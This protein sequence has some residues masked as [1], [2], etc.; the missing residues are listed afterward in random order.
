[1][2]VSFLGLGRMGSAMAERLLSSGVDLIVYNRTRE[3]AHPLLAKGASWAD[4]PRAASHNCEILLT[5]VSDDTSL[6][7]LMD[8]PEGFLDGL[9]QGS[10][11]VSLSTISLPFARSIEKS[12]FVRKIGLVSAP[13]F[14]R[15]TAVTSGTLRLLCAGKE[16]DTSRVL[17]LL[18]TLGSR[19]FMLGELPSV[20]NLVKLA[21]NFMISSALETLG[22]TFALTKKA[23]VDPDLFLEIVN[24]SLFRSPLYENYGR[25]MADR[26]YGKAGF[27]MDLGLKDVNLVLEASNALQVPLPLASVVRDSLLSGLAHGRSKLDWSAILLSSYDRS[28]LG[29]DTQKPAR[30]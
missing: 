8:G 15:P 28:G 7:A 26:S 17:P 2:K 25:I 10:I 20:A 21:G 6:E 11:H 12:H 19:V 9:P 27:T 18:E 23:G 14:G 13:V 3:K 29:L 16:E 30:E 5:M 24:D 1:M 22:E 4:T